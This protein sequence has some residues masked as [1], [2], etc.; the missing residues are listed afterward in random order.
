MK[1]RAKS[2]RMT[3]TGYLPTTDTRFTIDPA[4]DLGVRQL[5]KLHTFPDIVL[6]YVRFKHDEI[7]ATG[8]DPVITVD[9]LCS[10]NG[11]PP[12]RLIDPT[13]DLAKQEPSLLPAP[14][15]LR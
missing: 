7:S 2:G 14:W 6:Q 10:L 13:V 1:L 3:I 9:W 5:R 12:R 15:I 8:A 11:K 4:E